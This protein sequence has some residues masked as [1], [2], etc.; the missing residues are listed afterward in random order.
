MRTKTLSLIIPAYN[1]QDRLAGFLTSIAAY[2]EQHP[3]RLTEII[4]VD[5]GSTDGTAQVINSFRVALPILRPIQHQ[6]N[7]GKGA[8]VRTG[9]LAA[10]G[11]L[12]VFMD[13]DGATPITEIPK[14]ATALSSADIAVG[15]RWM[16][17]ANTERHSYLRSLS[18]WVYRNYMQ[19]F[20]L[21]SID[22]M[23][24]FK[25]YHRAVALDLYQNLQ[26]ERWLFD[27]EIA[28][29]ARLHGYTV[30]N[31]PIHWTSQDGSKLSTLTLLHSALN[32]LPLIIHLKRHEKLKL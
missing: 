20:G 22:T 1:E 30:K 7:R 6:A 21:G 23:C 10:S 2:I 13:A 27:T 19:L 17:G 31:F 26:E 24:G 12:L 16:H 29:R 14:I 9:F 28:Y 32:I 4:V 18:G 11:D 3:S 25:G 8:A 5:D 15:N